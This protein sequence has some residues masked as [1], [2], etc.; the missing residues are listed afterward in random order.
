MLFREGN[1]EGKPTTVALADGHEKQSIFTRMS[2][3]PDHPCVAVDFQGEAKPANHPPDPWL[4]ASIVLLGV[5]SRA[6][7][8]LRLRGHGTDVEPRAAVAWSSRERG[9]TAAVRSA[10]IHTKR[11]WTDQIERTRSIASAMPPMQTPL[12][13]A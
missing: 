5:F 4:T 11:R 9:N 7:L 13:L 1:G 8:V 6:L 10:T 3:L 12:T 2:D